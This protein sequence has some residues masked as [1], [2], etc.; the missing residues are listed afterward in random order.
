MS[1][2]YHSYLFVNGKEIYKFKADDKI[3]NFPTYLCKGSISNKLGAIDSREVSL[4][5]NGYD[6]AVGYN[7]IN[8]S[9]ILNIHKYL[10]VK[11][12]YEMFG[13]FKKMFIGLKH[14]TYWVKHI[15]WK[16]NHKF[17]SKNVI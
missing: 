7:A 10:M 6:A 3:V 5:G 1:L 4:K 8:K 11:K 9:D 2:H 14:K 13:Y 17:N 16:C 15:S 12:T